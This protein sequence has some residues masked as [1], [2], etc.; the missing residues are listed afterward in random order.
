MQVDYFW[1]VVSHV[2]NR[3]KLDE[4]NRKDPIRMGRYICST[5]DTKGNNNTNFNA[6]SRTSKCAANK[7]QTNRIFLIDFGKRIGM[8]G[9]NH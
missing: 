4:S 1:E 6:L 7:V 9:T 5:P 3:R 2:N 8:I